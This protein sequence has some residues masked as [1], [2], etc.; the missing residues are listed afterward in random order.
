[1]IPT[2]TQTV[3]MLD[4]TNAT[5]IPLG[6]KYAAGYVNG[7]WQS[8]NPMVARLPSAEVFSISIKY[9]TPAYWIDRE[10]GDASP[11]DAAQQ[12]TQGL[13]FGI[14]VSLE[15]WGAVITA[16]GQGRK[17]LYWIADYIAND[18]PVPTAIPQAWIDLGCVAWQYRDTGPYDESLLLI[19]NPLPKAG[20]N[21]E[22]GQVTWTDGKEHTAIF[23]PANGTGNP[24][25]IVQ[26]SA[27]DATHPLGIWEWFDLTG[28]AETVNGKPPAVAI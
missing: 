19:S 20:A 15:A 18:A 3:T 21:M 12:I 22:Y 28:A 26:T 8:Y 23:Y 1:M 27:P 11:L 6:T 9:G 16:V 7:K 17:P 25:C 14:Y 4:S 10:Y 24:T 2:A 5:N 13:S